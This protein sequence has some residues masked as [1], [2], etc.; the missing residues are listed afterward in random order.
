MYDVLVDARNRVG[1]VMG[2]HL[3]PLGA[4]L[5]TLGQHAAVPTAR[6]PHR[7]STQGTSKGTLLVHFRYTQGTLQG[8]SGYT[9]GTLEAHSGYTQ[10][11]I[12]LLSRYTPGTLKVHLRYI[13]GTVKGH[14]GYT[15]RIPGNTRPT[16]GCT[17]SS[18]ASPYLYT[19]HEQR[20]T[21]GT[22]KVHSRYTQ[23]TLSEAG[24][25]S[26]KS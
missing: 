22:I 6:Q 9:E 17:D 10:G 1:D 13:Q 8:H 18:P 25:H 14:S 5:G 11:T 15:R 24:H 7:T 21:L 20:Y 26:V 23:G 12:K 16:R 2:E 19:G 3:L 4:H